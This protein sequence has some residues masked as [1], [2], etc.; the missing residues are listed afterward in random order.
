VASVLLST[1]T[2]RERMSNNA[3]HRVRQHFRW[4]HVAAAVDELYTDV[5]ERRRR[6]TI[7]VENVAAYRSELH[8]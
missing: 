7:H 6:R 8:A 3:I 1:R 5:I 4:E 2:L